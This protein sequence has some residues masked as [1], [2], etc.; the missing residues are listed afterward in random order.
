MPLDVLPSSQ[1]CQI[2]NQIS[3]P[4]TKNLS[5]SEFGFCS[6]SSH[7]TSPWTGFNRW[8]PFSFKNIFMPYSP[9]NLTLP[10]AEEEAQLVKYL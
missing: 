4:I 5:Q 9:D 10:R 2:Q 1:A 7:S 3:F 8:C 6:L